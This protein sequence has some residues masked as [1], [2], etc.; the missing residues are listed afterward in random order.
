MGSVKTSKSRDD[1]MA[2]V[3]IFKANQFY[4]FGQTR[5]YPTCL[6]VYLQL[7]WDLIK[8][9]K[10]TVLT[11]HVSEHWDIKYPSGTRQ[12]MGSHIPGDNCRFLPSTDRHRRP[13]SVAW[14]RVNNLCRRINNWWDYISYRCAYQYLKRGAVVILSFPA[15]ARRVLHFWAS[16]NTAALGIG[17]AQAASQLGYITARHR[18]K[19]HDLWRRA[20][21]KRSTA[22]DVYITPGWNWT[23]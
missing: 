22:G 9:S 21:Q 8:S 14:V 1:L 13:V 18:H 2:A 20:V 4:I 3:F 11:S 19:R 12:W 7:N 15:A 6:C 23:T 10:I 16:L 17:G 5:K